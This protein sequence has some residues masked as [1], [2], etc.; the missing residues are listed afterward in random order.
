MKKTLVNHN[1]IIQWKIIISNEEE[2]KQYTMLKTKILGEEFLGMLTKKLKGD[3][4]EE[5]QEQKLLRLISQTEKVPLIN[6]CGLLVKELVI[7]MHSYILKK[8]TIVINAAG[9]YCPWDDS[10]MKVVEETE[11]NIA[12]A[13]G[14]QVLKDEILFNLDNGPFI[15]LENDGV[16]P[17]DVESYISNTLGVDKFS[18]IKS[19]NLEPE[20]M[21]DLIKEALAKKHHTFI[22]Q[23]TMINTEQ[24]ESVVK[25]ME[26]IPFKVNFLIKTFED[27]KE[28]LGFVVGKERVGELYKKHNIVE[29]S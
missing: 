29:W 21:S 8:Q 27:I 5:S 26:E 22:I 17:K 23:T 28:K 7:A 6:S 15:V 10:C 14:K 24:I 3:S 18:Y 4:N 16:I 25:I 12:I 2:L 9:G 1:G 20:R 11:E 13:D 19:I